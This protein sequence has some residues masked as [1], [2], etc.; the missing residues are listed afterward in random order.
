MA[1]TRND[2]GVSLPQRSRSR[3]G[4]RQLAHLPDPFSRRLRRPRGDLRDH[5]AARIRPRHRARRQDHEPARRAAHGR[6]AP[7]RERPPCGPRGRARRLCPLAALPRGARPR[8]R[9]GRPRHRADRRARERHR[10]RADLRRRRP[11]PRRQRRLVQQEHQADRERRLRL[12]GRPLAHRHRR[13]RDARG[14]GLPV[15]PRLRRRSS[16]TT[17]RPRRSRTRSSRP[18]RCSAR[19]ATSHA[20]SSSASSGSSWSRQPT[21]TRRTRRSAWTG[22]S[23]S[24]TTVRTGRCSSAR[25]PSG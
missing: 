22:L 20:R 5:R 23:Q 9:R 19:S 17:R 11:D 8:A 12:A 10:L 16:W 2:P 7:V 25:S 18:T 15:H 6:A 1:S 14:R 4:V 24:S 13:A 3:R 21:T